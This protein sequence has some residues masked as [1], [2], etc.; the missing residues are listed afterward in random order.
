MHETNERGSITDGQRRAVAEAMR[1]ILEDDL[2]RADPRQP[3]ACP[4]CGLR[5]D[6]AGSVEY[7][8]T[9]LCHECATR[10]ELARVSGTLRSSSEFVAHNGA[11]IPT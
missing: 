6:A 9:R 4:G 10:F 8:Q 2:E 5:R 7:E 11:K 3:F 1:V